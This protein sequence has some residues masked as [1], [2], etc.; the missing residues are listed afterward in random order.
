MAARRRSRQT[1]PDRAIPVAKRG[2][3]RPPK[4]N[5]AL[6]EKIAWLVAHGVYLSD[7]A[8]ECDVGRATLY[9]WLNDPRPAYRE[10]AETLRQAEAEA[11]LAAV[12]KMLRSRDWRAHYAW[13][14]ARYPDRW[15]RRPLRR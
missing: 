14:H 7:A 11:E 10:F 5:P 12:T 15:P 4:F 9:R 2:A 8:A 6:A 13:L 3:G 1:T